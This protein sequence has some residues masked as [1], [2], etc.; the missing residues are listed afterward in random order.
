MIII[1]GTLDLTD[2][3]KRDEAH[4]AVLDLMRATR[5]EAGCIH[6]A[7][8]ADVEDPAR[9]HIIEHWE[10]EEALKTHFGASHMATFQAAL[11]GLGVKGLD[12]QRYDIA[13]V[14][15]VFG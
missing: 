9:F 7:F 3:A 2:G 12:V 11:G 6:Y 15:P 8:S 5:K 1:S 4:G 10:S 14:R 13:A